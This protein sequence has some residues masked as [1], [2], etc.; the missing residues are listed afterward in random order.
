LPDVVLILER[1][2]PAAFLL[3]ILVF[4]GNVQPLLLDCYGK[5][6]Q[7]GSTSTCE[8]SK[9]CSKKEAAG[10]SSGKETTRTE[11][12]N[13]F[14]SC[15]GCHYVINLKVINLRISISSV[16]VKLFTGSEDIRSGFMSD[17][18]HPP[19]SGLS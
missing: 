13:P 16:K 14:A 15:S 3:I 7:P 6:K 17:C 4:F 10:K 8:A 1:M 2:N 12:C 19:E 11:G 9:R 18:W 5:T